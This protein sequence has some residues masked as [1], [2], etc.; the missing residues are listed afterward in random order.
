MKSRVSERKAR[1]GLRCIGTSKTILA[2]PGGGITKSLKLWLLPRQPAGQ[3]EYHRFL[4]YGW[5]RTS[6]GF[7]GLQSRRSLPKQLIPNVL[8]RE[9]LCTTHFPLGFLREHASASLAPV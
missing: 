3:Q 7:A 1:V 8:G 9:R 2:I 5:G 6:P 4:V